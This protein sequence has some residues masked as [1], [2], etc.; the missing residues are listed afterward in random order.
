MWSKMRS[1][2]VHIDDD[3]E[4]V[5]STTASDPSDEWR[6][7]ESRRLVHTSL[8]SLV[9]SIPMLSSGS[10]S[11]LPSRS[12]DRIAR[13]ESPFLSSRYCNLFETPSRRVLRLPG[14]RSG[15]AGRY[16]I[17]YDA[18]L[19]K[20]SFGCVFA[21]RWRGTARLPAQL[22]LRQVDELDSAQL[23]WFDDLSKQSRP[24][25]D[26]VEGGDEPPFAVKVTWSRQ[27]MKEI[28]M[29]MRCQGPGI[30]LFIEHFSAKGPCGDKLRHIVTNRCFGTAADRVKN[31]D[32]T[33][34][35]S[36]ALKCSVQLLRAVAHVHAQGVVHRDVKP[37]NV[38]CTSPGINTDVALGDFGLAAIGH[39]VPTAGSWGFWDPEAFDGCMTQASD[40]WALAVTALR[41]CGRDMGSGKGISFGK[42][43][44]YNLIRHG[45][46][47]QQVR[48]GGVCVQAGLQ[49]YLL[50]SFDEDSCTRP[51]CSELKSTLPA[52][53]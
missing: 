51:T 14:R 49:A 26:S 6:P 40:V 44:F 23:K 30:L 21:A 15:H 33:V 3:Q 28:H 48:N 46:A 10:S 39:R 18:K 37:P 2:K 35:A 11:Q 45:H 7:T 31:A 13:S 9:D 5:E 43:M 12:E 4:S 17:E 34:R 27:P 53:S 1:V 16:E 19:G 36:F 24:S 38:F 29:L 50:A 47:R 41:L 8:F 20:G 42:D 32:A 52:L 22:A 25:R